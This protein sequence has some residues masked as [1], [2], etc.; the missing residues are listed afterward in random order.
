[1]YVADTIAAIA[2][3]AGVG[4]VGILRISGPMSL[5]IA[6]RVTRSHQPL[7]S[8]Q[9]RRLYRC[10]MLSVD[11]A[12]ID[13]G[14]AAMMRAPHSYSGEDLIELHCHGSP[15]VL[16][17]LLAHV[18]SCGARLADPGEFTK[19]AF[20][21]GRLDLAQA[22][23]V[24]DLIQA[25]T[26]AAATLAV[27]QL[28]GQLTAALGRVR[29]DLIRVKALL[30]AQIDFSEE[31]V[32]VTIAE[33]AAPLDSAYKA[34]TRLVDSYKKGLVLRIGARVVI[35]GKPNVGKS[36]LLNALLGSERAIVTNVPGTTRDTIDESLDFDG[37]PVVLTDTAGLRASDQVEIVER[38]GIQR[39]QAAL[40]EA[41]LRLVVLDNSSRFEPADQALLDSVDTL[42]YLLVVNKADL[43]QSLSA[44][45][46]DAASGAH[47]AVYVSAKTL[48]GLSAL[49]QA[50]K[51][52]LLRGSDLDDGGFV[53]HPRHHAA[54]L[55]AQQSLR[56]ARQ[57]VMDGSP[58]D[59]TAVDLQDALD[60]VG[61]IT[62]SV[63]SED[64]LD[65]IF[66]EFCI[67]K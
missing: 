21:N 25:R 48:Q 22:E 2:T 30:E 28:D 35:V 67:G 46:V 23:A 3:P 4:A 15:V 26:P 53:S 52:M 8:W 16:R 54:L 60:H 51:E 61:S 19:R 49:R 40:Q 1:M 58:A 45:D 7:S 59:I 37:V 39:T 32:R 56:L 66:A 63:T 18:L 27:K 24:A 55:L 62:G 6:A 38:I 41:A 50:A 44:A 14:L 34:I 42:P 9:P 13:H 10:T 5:A 33:L 43:P 57:A 12:V 65:R 29:D 31:D 64:V 17:H 36:S 20:L 47:R 11:A